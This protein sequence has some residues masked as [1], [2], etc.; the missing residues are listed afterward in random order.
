MA[1]VQIK[2][3]KCDVCSH[4]WISRDRQREQLPIACAKCESPYWNKS[5][6]NK[7]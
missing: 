4:I 6:R 1:I 2:A 3:Y 7:Q 5:E